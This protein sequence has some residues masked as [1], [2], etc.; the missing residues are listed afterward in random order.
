MR[1]LLCAMCVVF[2]SL[3]GDHAICA[4]PDVKQL[5]K[6]VVCQNRDDDSR[7]FGY[8]YCCVDVRGV[9]FWS[10]NISCSESCPASHCSEKQL[11]PNC[12]YS[13]RCDQSPERNGFL[14]R[15]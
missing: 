14:F 10:S 1:K 5:R 12:Q 4:C 8:A 9:A 13:D 15:F 7:P 3:W 6:C 2:S 11:P